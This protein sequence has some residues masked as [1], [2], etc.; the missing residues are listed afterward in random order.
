MNLKDYYSFFSSSTPTTTRT[1]TAKMKE[2]NINNKYPG[3]KAKKKL[4]L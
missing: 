2:L 4:L 3:T 1:T